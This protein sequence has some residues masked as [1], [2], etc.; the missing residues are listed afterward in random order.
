MSDFHLPIPN[1]LFGRASV[2]D[3]IRPIPTIRF[4]RANSPLNLQDALLPILLCLL[5]QF[6][7]SLELLKDERRQLGRLPVLLVVVGDNV[8]VAT[9]RRTLAGLRQDH[10]LQLERGLR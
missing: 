1:L 10:D 9:G 3:S 6:P 7:D 2:L 4:Q 8:F 5:L